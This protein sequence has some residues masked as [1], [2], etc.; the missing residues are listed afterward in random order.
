MSRSP[1]LRR[2]TV[3]AL[4]M[5]TAVTLTACSTSE[6]GGSERERRP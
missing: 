5:T 3:I 4:G 6:E 2:L 1:H